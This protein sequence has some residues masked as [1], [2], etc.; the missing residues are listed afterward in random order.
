ML[1]ILFYNSTFKPNNNWKRKYYYTFI[2]Y[3]YVLLLD[4]ATYQTK[5]MDNTRSWLCT[6]KCFQNY[7]CIYL[8]NRE[9]FKANVR[10]VF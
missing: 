7:F 9:N 2:I 6:A 10:F 5:M 3:L 1:T 4:V 8:R